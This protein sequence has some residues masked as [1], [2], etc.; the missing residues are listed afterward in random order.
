M[1][2]FNIKKFMPNIYGKNHHKFLNNFIENGEIK[3]LKV[4]KR[5]LF[6]KNNEKFIFPIEVKFKTEHLFEK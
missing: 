1:L 5:T 2:G 3:A 6:A 4:K